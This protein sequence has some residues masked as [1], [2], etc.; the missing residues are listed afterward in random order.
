MSII[1]AI[2]QTEMQVSASDAP[3]KCVKCGALLNLPTIA[4]Q[5]AGARASA[6]GPSSSEE[7]ASGGTHERT[8]L[9]ASE[10]PQPAVSE[11]ATVAPDSPLTPGPD[12]EPHA[13][14]STMDA[15]LYAFLAPA[16]A[17]DELGRLGPYRVLKVLGQGG[18]GVVFLAQD[19][20]LGR[21]VA[22]KAMLP[23][24]AAKPEA[25]ERFLREA[26][27]AAAIE[28][29]HI[30]AILQ[31]DEDRG[32]PY[33]AMPLLRG[34]TLE[35]WLREHRNEM[36]PLPLI[37]KLGRQIAMGLAAAHAAGLIHRDVKPANI[38]LQSTAIDPTGRYALLP[39]SPLMSDFRAKILDFGLAR[40][41]AGE[42]NL[43]QS[44]AILGTPAYM[45][46]EQARRGIKITNR[47]DLFS[48]G[49]V[50]FRLCTGQLPF[51]G[52]DVMSTLMATAMEEPAPPRQFNPAIPPSLSG[53]VLRLLSKD[54]QQRPAS[55]D[56]VVE[57]LEAMEAW[58]ADATSAPP[59]LEVPVATP[60]VT[61]AEPSPAPSQAPVY[62]A[63]PI[64]MPDEETPK[65]EKERARRRDGREAR[66]DSRPARRGR[67]ED[68]DIS[69]PP[70]KPSSVMSVTSLVLGLSSFLVTITATVLGLSLGLSCGCAVLGGYFGLAVGGV[71]AAGGIV[72][73]IIGLNQGGRPY[74]RAGIAS[75]AISLVMI[76][77][78]IVLMVV[79]GPNVFGGPG[80]FGPFGAP[81]R[82][83]PNVNINFNVPVDQNVPPKGGA[84]KGGAQPK[85]DVP[86]KDAP[87]KDPAPPNAAVNI[88]MPAPEIDAE[89]LDG[90]RMKLSDYRGKVVLLSFWGNWCP[91]CRDMVP[92]QQALVSRLA[93][94][95]FALIGVNSDKD[96][97]ALAPI[98]AREKI[99]WRSFWNG[100]NTDG[101]IS[102]AWGIDRWPTLFLID[103]KGVVKQKW[104]GSLPAPVLDK[105]I[106]DLVLQVQSD[107]AP[108]KD[109][110]GKEAP[111]KEAPVKQA[112]VK[113]APAKDAPPQNPPPKAVPPQDAAVNG[114][115]P[116]NQFLPGAS[117]AY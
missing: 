46:P 64:P 19:T 42:Q 44:G 82:P 83:P 105:A 92:Q 106:D 9:E 104:V 77:A 50:L 99:S 103:Q 7:R 32:V 6:A 20:R 87:V 18:M 91:P 71:L 17:P 35:S 79:L 74:A 41:S 37:L 52:D 11:S 65:A 78:Y 100:G 39:T 57:R 93:D 34:T 110:P 112:P 33:I 40:S 69:L 59:P 12:T 29:D 101:P 117:R 28:H 98:L 84:P 116:G 24:L 107:R 45:A 114:E 80:D 2:C 4:E 94:K 89:D 56:E 15:P 68:L 38:F 66:D 5:P 70:R 72:F 76:A 23:Q 62:A 109:A 63:V 21:Q 102:T 55:A 113:E 49:V 96:R 88:G 48:L 16:Q 90:K 8:A 53:L 86:L 10:A 3:V 36:L 27:T 51:Q 97:K 67:R 13:G 26:R 58:L 85:K 30:V 31:V 54:P 115:T 60:S 25:R 22:I 73:G 95:P 43:T 14:R 81:R 111:V 108:E 47:T 1:C 61:L 75:S